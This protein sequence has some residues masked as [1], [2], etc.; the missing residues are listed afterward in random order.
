M[1]LAEMVA[2]STATG[3]VANL[4]RAAAGLPPVYGKPR[5]EPRREYERLMHQRYGALDRA[6]P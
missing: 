1:T 3:Y 5:R 6:K 2:R 4:F